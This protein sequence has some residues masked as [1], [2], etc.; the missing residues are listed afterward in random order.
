METLQP[1]ELYSSFLPQGK[2]L[3]PSVFTYIFHVGSFFPLEMFPL[4]ALYIFKTLNLFLEQT[5]FFFAV[6][7]LLGKVLNQNLH[8]LQ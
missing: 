5:T 1:R 3:F 2:E 7:H 6:S 8:A 4:F